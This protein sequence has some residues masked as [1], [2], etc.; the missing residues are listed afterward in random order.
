M[1]YEALLGY[2]IMFGIFT[3]AAT[4]VSFVLFSLIFSQS[5]QYFNNHY[6]FI[7]WIHSV[8]AVSDWGN[9]YSVDAAARVC[10]KR[11]RASSTKTAAFNRNELETSGNGDPTIPYWTLWTMQF[12][13]MVPYF[14]GGVAKVQYDW[15]YRNE[16]FR[17]WFKSSKMKSNWFKSM[18]YDNALAAKFI[19]YGG[20]TFDL[21][22]PILLLTTI[23]VI[24][25]SGS[26][27]AMR[28]MSIPSNEECDAEDKDI[29]KRRS[30]TMKV[31]LFIRRHQYQLLALGFAGSLGFNTTNKLLLN[32]GVFPY[33]MM[34]SLIIFLPP[35]TV[36]R[37]LALL[38]SQT[39]RCVL[40]A[41][42]MTTPSALLHRECA[43]S[44]VP[45]DSRSA[46]RFARLRRQFGPVFVCAFVSFHIIWPIRGQL[47]LPPHVSWHEEGHI[48]AWNMKLRSKTGN[49]E[50]AFH[51][52]DLNDPGRA[53]SVKTYILDLYSTLGDPSVGGLMS[54]KG[55]KLKKNFTNRPYDVANYLQYM[56]VRTNAFPEEGR[57]RT[58]AMVMR[59]TRDGADFLGSCLHR[60]APFV[61]RARTFDDA[62]RAA[63]SRD[64]RVRGPEHHRRI[65]S[66]AECEAL[67]TFFHQRRG[68]KPVHRFVL[69]SVQHMRW[70]MGG[71][72]RAAAVVRRRK[73]VCGS[74]WI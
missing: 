61:L 69:V 67:T 65:L 56:R 74:S 26:Q 35:G 27:Y 71:T 3:K 1:R 14:F 66:V 72:A 16:P 52:T 13:Y 49:A 57:L 33:A 60:T 37:Y 45:F 19:S 11:F 32:I 50:F 73:E 43:T 55:M 24:V 31:F 63:S 20:V 51:L 40:P 36:D 41:A 17:H 29:S 21:F 59:S 10:Y 53:E 12:L 46:S 25:L 58:V 4:C 7:I 8:G 70:Q 2:M 68:L 6:V 39:R 38:V 42:I 28:M 9:S 18:F 62:M 48:G 34:W 15:I 5:S 30:T 44:H 23:T 47:L 54:E 64:G 22:E